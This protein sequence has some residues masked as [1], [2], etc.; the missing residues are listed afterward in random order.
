MCERE[1]EKMKKEEGRRE[2]EEKK[3][4]RD[5]ETQQNRLLRGY[6]SK[7]GTQTTSTIKFPKPPAMCCFPSLIK[8][9]KERLSPL[10]P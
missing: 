2:E 10:K 5:R 8:A 7:K 6:E 9:A 3:G 1:R 4:G